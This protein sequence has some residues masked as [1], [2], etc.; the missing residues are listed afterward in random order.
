LFNDQLVPSGANFYATNPS[1][2]NTTDL[3]ANRMGVPNCAGFENT[4]QCMGWDARTGTLTTPSVISD[5]TASCTQCTGK[6]FQR[7]SVTCA[8]NADYPT[9]LKG[10]VYLHAVNGFVAG[11][12]IV[13]RVGLVTKP[14]GL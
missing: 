5:L 9:W 10:I 7:P 6:G 1:F 11:T 4:T 13:Q 14:C 2:T 3:L 8:P 12:P